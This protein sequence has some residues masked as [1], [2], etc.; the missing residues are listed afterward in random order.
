MTP[1][2]ARH[3]RGSI[4]Q[5]DKA[6]SWL[7]TFYVYRHSF[8]SNVALLCVPKS[9]SGRPCVN[10]SLG[11]G[12]CVAL[13]IHFVWVSHENDFWHHGAYGHRKPLHIV[14]FQDSV[15]KLRRVAKQR[16][17]STARSV[18]TAATLFPSHFSSCDTALALSCSCVCSVFNSFFLGDVTPRYGSC[19]KSSEDS[20][21][22][23]C[24]GHVR[25]FPLVWG[26]HVGVPLA[27]VVL[28][29]AGVALDHLA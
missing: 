11:A 2:E 13:T 12:L 19:A 27:L 16:K 23:R 9:S 15:M 4:L 21:K 24:L 17:Q 26:L 3:L 28:C 22:F 5:I 6:L 18:I 7:A 8:S 25:G 20:I 14:V 10:Y 1:P 29:S